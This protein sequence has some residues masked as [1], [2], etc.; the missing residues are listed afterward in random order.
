VLAPAIGALVGVGTSELW[1]RPGH[2]GGSH[3]LV[4]AL[5]VTV[6]WTWAVLAR[7]P[8]FVPWLRVA[9]VVI[10]LVAVD[11]LSAGR[12]FPASRMGRRLGIV[13]AGAALLTALAEPAAYAVDT[14][15]SPHGGAI[16]SAGPSAAFG[17]GS[18][19]GD[20]GG[21]GH[22][23]GGFDGF[24]PFRR[25]R[26]NA[27][28]GASPSGPPPSGRSRVPGGHG[29]S[30]CG[31]LGGSNPSSQLVALVRADASRYPWVAAAAGSNTAAGYQL[32][33]GDPVMPVGGFNGTDPSPTFSSSNSTSLSERSITL[34]VA[35]ASADRTWRQ[36]QPAGRGL[37][38]AALYRP[39][40]RQRHALRLD[41]G[42]VVSLPHVA[43]PP[44]LRYG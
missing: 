43:L 37:G 10:G 16:P 44:W 5:L 41:G 8:D 33:T 3:L 31:L 40:G 35:A 32:A 27:G 17:T 28:F 12:R 20:P 38:S 34:S 25:A 14:A 2:D 30:I 15:A 22:S 6:V 18:F 7:N 21:F 19:R 11:G 39:H 13:V 1:R 42:S 23:R 9:V 24:A 29:G 26:L 36:H 4:S